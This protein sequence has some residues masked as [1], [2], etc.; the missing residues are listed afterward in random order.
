MNSREAGTRLW[1][2][3]AHM[4]STQDREL[5]LVRGEGAYVWDEAGRRYFD[6]P[7][8]LWFCNVGHGRSEIGEAIA[9]QIG[10]LECYNVFGR[11]AT[12]PTLELA[13]LLADLVPMEQARIFFTSGG[14]DGVDAAAKIV[15]RYWSAVGRPR[16]KMIVT[17]DLSYHGLH[18]FGTSMS[19]LASNQEGLGRFIP[20]TAVVDRDDAGDLRRLFESCGHEIA[21]F[22]FEPIMGTGGVHLPKPGYLAEVQ[23]L[24]REHDI[25]LVSDEV[26]TGFGRLG[27]WFG[28]TR[29]GITP[30]VMVMAKGLTS[31]YMPL[32]AVA[33]GARVAE[34]FWGGP[35]AQ[36]L[37]HGMTYSGHAAACAAALTNL[38]ILEREGLRTAAETLGAVLHQEVQ[39][40]RNLPLVAEVRSGV[41]LMAGVEL[42]DPDV[43]IAASAALLKRGHIVRAITNGTLQFSPPF[44]ATE[45]DVTDC[46][47]SVRE[48]ISELAEQL[49][50]VG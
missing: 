44:V 39:S 43:A 2:C 18:A 3:Q 17:R 49:A 13:D 20:D 8:S 27:S 16:K 14:S 31:G 37:R 6:S 41:G 29:F 34:P 4:P 35:D 33:L 42:V 32:G 50:A 9:N 28:S 45:S 19:G 26:I 36:V 22:F 47:E 48:V 30:D 23:R 25:L 46:V 24:C 21:A 11:F 7:A 10:Q 38:E 1:H 40:L 5:V 15:R 12:R